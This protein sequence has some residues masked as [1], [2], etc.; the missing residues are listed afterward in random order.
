L[1][2]KIEQNWKLRNVLNMLKERISGFFV[3]R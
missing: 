1:A 3:R 2:K